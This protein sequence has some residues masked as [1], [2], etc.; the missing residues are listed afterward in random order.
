MSNPNELPEYKVKRNGTP[1]ERFGTINEE[2]TGKTKELM[3]LPSESAWVR[4]YRVVPGLMTHS[5]ITDVLLYLFP[6]NDVAS[7]REKRKMKRL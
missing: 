7:A 6:E 3:M 4:V 1:A 2:F 5:R